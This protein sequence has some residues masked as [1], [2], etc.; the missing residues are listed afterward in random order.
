MIQEAWR[1]LYRTESSG[2]LVEY[3]NLDFQSYTNFWENSIQN[4]SH[5][6]ASWPKIRLAGWTSC[7]IGAP[8]FDSCWL[9][10]WHSHWLVHGCVAEIYSWVVELLVHFSPRF[11]LN[12]WFCVKA[13]L[14]C[15]NSASD[16][17]FCISFV[18]LISL[19]HQFSLFS[20]N[21]LLT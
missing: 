19:I 21:L 2:T 10:S 1:R 6:S 4:H 16:H 14:R 8:L 5:S 12:F 11:L 20:S 15:S 18:H 7:C 13:L 9:L 17:W 3:K